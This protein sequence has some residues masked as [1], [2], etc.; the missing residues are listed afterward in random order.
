ML[1]TP[2]A[3]LATVGEATVIEVPLTATALPPGAPAEAWAHLAVY[4]VRGDA[5]R[6]PGP[7][8]PGP[9]PPRP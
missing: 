2:A 3:D 7:S 8:R 9:S 6:S 4:R 5:A 1:I